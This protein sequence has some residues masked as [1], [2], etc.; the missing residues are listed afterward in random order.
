MNI[1]CTDINFDAYDVYLGPEK[2]L[3]K[4]GINAKILEADDEQGII[5][6]KQYADAK[7]ERVF[8][9]VYIVRTR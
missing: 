6:W 7:Q 8:G 2:F 1:K 5:I 3:N 4:K 9:K